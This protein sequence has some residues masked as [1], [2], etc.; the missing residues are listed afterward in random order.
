MNYNDYE[1]VYYAKEN[2]DDGFSLLLKKYDRLIYKICYGYISY[3]NKFKIDIDDLVQECRYNLYYSLKYFNADK[4]ILF[5]SYVILITRRKLY[6]I[7][8]RYYKRNFSL[9]D[10]DDDN[11][12]LQVSD[13]YVYNP[14]YIMI[15]SEI[16]Y[17]LIC[18][19]NGLSFEDA[20]IF[21]MRFCSFSYEDIALMVDLSVKQVDN[22]LTKIRK[23]LK[24]YLLNI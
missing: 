23:K 19:K 15:E 1:L 21:D 11:N 20:V 18:F 5:Y 16:F 17:N 12:Y 13:N 4:D 9:V 7:F 14:D 10:L 24:N 6:K 8:S 3:C 2:D 22:R